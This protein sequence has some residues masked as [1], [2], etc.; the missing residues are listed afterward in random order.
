MF[1]KL[2]QILIDYIPLRNY[3]QVQK[4]RREVKNKKNNEIKNIIIWNK[5]FSKY[6]N[7]G[8]DTSID[9]CQKFYEIN[10][11]CIKNVKINLEKNDPIV[12]FMVKNDLIRTK[13]ILNYYRKLGIKLFAVL[14]DS[15]TDGTYE[16]LYKQNDVDLYTSNYS[17][18]TNIRQARINR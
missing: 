11:N 18:T 14:D 15:S 16:F 5:A 13:M 2:R 1:L 7:I 3:K 12:I 8:S 4:I 17:Y 9:V 10:L 6:I